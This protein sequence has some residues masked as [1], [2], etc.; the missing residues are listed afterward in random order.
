MKELSFDAIP[1]KIQ[2]LNSRLIRIEHL[3]KTKGEK[4]ET[5]QWFDLDQ[6][7]N[8]LPGHP[9][10]QTIYGLVSNRKIPF[11]KRGKRL[12]FSKKSIDLWIAEGRQKTVDEIRNEI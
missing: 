1:A 5:D 10:K 4:A 9:A 8:Y 11:H 2:E 3:L 6:L 12:I 7:V